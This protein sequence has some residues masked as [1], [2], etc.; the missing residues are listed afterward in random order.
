MPGIITTSSYS[1]LAIFFLSKALG[2]EESHSQHI[3]CSNNSDHR[4]TTELG[5]VQLAVKEGYQ[6]EHEGAVGNVQQE[7]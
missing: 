5:G 2:L 7:E 1:P 3:L 4:A 6:E